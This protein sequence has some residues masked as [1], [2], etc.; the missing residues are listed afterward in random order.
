MQNIVVL[1]SFVALSYAVYFAEAYLEQKWF[2]SENTT[3]TA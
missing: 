1:L 2:E 3:T